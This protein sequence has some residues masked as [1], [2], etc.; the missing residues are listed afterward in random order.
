V[1]FTDV[2]LNDGQV[3]DTSADFHL[4]EAATSGWL[5]L[6]LAIILDISMTLA[7]GMHTATEV[8]DVAQVSLNVTQRGTQLVH[9]SLVDISYI[10]QR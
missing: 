5:C 8:S 10:N 4:N 2:A 6:L 7:H 1:N 3:F 9:T